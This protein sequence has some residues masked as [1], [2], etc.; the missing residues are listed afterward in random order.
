MLNEYGYPG[1]LSHGQAAHLNKYRH[2]GDLELFDEAY[3]KEK[4]KAYIR[5]ES[6]PVMVRHILHI[7]GL[8]LSDEKL[9]RFT[10]EFTELHQHVTPRPDAVSSLK[11]LKADGYKICVLTDSYYSSI[12]KMKW[13]KTIGMAGFID[14]I[15]SSY[16]IRK[17]KDTPEAYQTCLKVLGVTAK[18]A[19]FV[20]HQQY[21][22]TG[23]K[24]A[25]V[26]SVAILPI[27]PQNIRSDY[28]VSSLSELPALL[29]KL[30][31]E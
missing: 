21:E 3:E 6:V 16:D 18:E 1:K 25:K 13:F 27:A 9:K 19:I 17:L 22:M 20:G 15:V 7:L 23:A 30:N 2:L 5:D 12:E 10:V 29:L 8:E 14:K 24:S 28:T 31:H 11:K 4:V 26:L